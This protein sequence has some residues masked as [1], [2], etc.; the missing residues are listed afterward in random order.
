MEP[1]IEIYY[2][3]IL[4]RTNKYQVKIAI[5]KNL[6]KN[7]EEEELRREILE[8]YKI[9]YKEDIKTIEKYYILLYCTC[10]ILNEKDKNIIYIEIENS[11]Q[12]PYNFIVYCFLKSF[13][14]IIPKS[15]LIL[16]SLF[17]IISESLEYNFIKEYL[18]IIYN[19]KENVLLEFIEECIFIENKNNKIYWKENILLFLYN[20]IS[21]KL[22]YYYLY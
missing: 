14:K 2:P 13:N 15:N 12:N 1:K 19:I 3:R 16:K 7:I 11:K 4:N 20:K 17:N 18:Y 5:I 8:I 9:I 10:Y 6:L 21:I 22:F